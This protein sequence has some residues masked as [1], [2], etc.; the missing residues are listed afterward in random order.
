MAVPSLR[1]RFHDWCS[2]V[3]VERLSALTP[4]EV[5]RRS[6]PDE[7]WRPWSPE[8]RENG[9]D[10]AIYLLDGA[11]GLGGEADHFRRLILSLLSDAPLPSFE[12]W[13]QAYKSDPAPFDE[14]ILGLG[15]AQESE[16][17]RGALGA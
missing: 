13:S 14:V 10:A 4:D 16:E 12:E 17:T 15:E 7:S 3:I 6:R 9:Q 1:E 5:Y 8:P 2:A 11:S